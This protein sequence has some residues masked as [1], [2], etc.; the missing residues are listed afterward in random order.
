[1]FHF[2]RH[3]AWN[4]FC[5]LTADCGCARARHPEARTYTRATSHSTDSVAALHCQN[6]RPQWVEPCPFATRLHAGRL[7]HLDKRPLVGRSTDSRGWSSCRARVVNSLPFADGQQLRQGTLA[8][9]ADA[10][11][12]RSSGQAGSDDPVMTARFGGRPLVK[13][14]EMGTTEA[15]VVEPSHG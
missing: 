6:E 5:R 7:H 4:A 12:S 11:S 14:L 8:V 9:T 2:A 13:A 3:R 1:M 15:H 10:Q